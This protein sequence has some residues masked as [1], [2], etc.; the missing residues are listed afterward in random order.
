MKYLKSLLIL[1]ILVLG[2]SMVNAQ[3]RQYTESRSVSPQNLE[4]KVFKEIMKLPYYGVFDHIAFRVEGSTVTLYGKVANAR[5]KKD[6]ERWV[7]DINGV[8]RV[9]NNIDILPLSGFDYSIRRGILQSFANSGGLYRYLWEPRPSVR[10]IV[11]GGHVSLEGYVANRGDFNLMNI[12]ANGISGVFSV[13][14]N[15]VIEKEM[16]R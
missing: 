10:I 3:A 9:V 4:R 11:D 12:L 16:V 13:K 2:F 7:A 14:N 5:N 6:A 1:A 8:K 15:L